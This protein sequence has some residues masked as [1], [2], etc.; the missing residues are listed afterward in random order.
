MARM[1]RFLAAVLAAT[2][3]VALALAAALAD[4]GRPPRPA[5]S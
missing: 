1:A 3:L 2:T 4:T 5:S